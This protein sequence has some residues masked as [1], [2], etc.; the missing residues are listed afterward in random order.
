MQYTSPPSVPALKDQKL[1][2]HCIYGGTPLPD[3]TWS[4]R[5]SKIEGSHFTYNNYGKTLVINKVDFSDEGV[6]EC[7]ASNGIGS[8]RTHAMEVKVNAAPFWI[9]Y[10]NDTN[11]AEGETVSFKC[12]A[13]GIPEPKL[14]WFV[15]GVPIEKAPTNNR[16]KVEGSVLTV[17]D[18]I[19]TV[20][21]SVFQCNASNVHGYAFRDFYLNVLKLPP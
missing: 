12:I 4:K 21:T 17:T 5:G 16:R 1:E 11:A 6:Y 19:E 7:T 3:I 13:S 9:E 14:Q 18:L 20:D 10:P 8:Q 2:L 15:N